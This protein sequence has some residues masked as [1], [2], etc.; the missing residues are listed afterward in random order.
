MMWVPAAP[1]KMG[2]CS[3]LRQGDLIAA[4][5]DAALAKPTR[6][7]EAVGSGA[8]LLIVNSTI[9]Q[10][11]PTLPMLASPHWRAG[12]PVRPRAFFFRRFSQRR[13]VAS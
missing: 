12:L 1:R 13:R 6:M 2:S 10:P 9:W 3:R 5:E 7:A 11:G 4:D 8:E